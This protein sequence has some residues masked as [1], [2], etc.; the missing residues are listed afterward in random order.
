M[1]VSKDSDIIDSIGE[2]RYFCEEEMRGEFP[3]L[4]GPIGQGIENDAI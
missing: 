2:E 3:S 4:D 1:R